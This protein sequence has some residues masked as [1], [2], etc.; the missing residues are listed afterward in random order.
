[1][2][3]TSPDVIFSKFVI[4]AVLHNAAVADRLGLQGVD[5]AALV[6]LEVG[7]PLPVGALAEEL[8]LPSASATRLVD[9]LERAGYARRVRGARDRRTVTVELA[10]GGMDEYRTASESVTR[11]LYEVGA[12]YPPEQAPIMLDMLARVTGAYRSAT[13]ELRRSDAGQ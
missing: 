3:D 13:E 11:R 7:G 1:M 10:E 6:L 2:P 4:S 8:G 12:H 9:R 5:V